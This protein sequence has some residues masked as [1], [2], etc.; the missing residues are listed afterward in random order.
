MIGGT[1]EVDQSSGDFTFTFTGNVPSDNPLA[2]A[3]SLGADTK[4]VPKAKAAPAKL[5]GVFGNLAKRAMNLFLEQKRAGRT[6]VCKTLAATGATVKWTG[7]GYIFSFVGS[8]LLG[9]MCQSFENTSRVMTFFLKRAGVPKEE[10]NKQVKDMQER[11]LDKKLNDPDC[12]LKERAKFKQIGLFQIHGKDSRSSKYIWT[13]LEGFAYGGNSNFT[14][15]EVIMYFKSALEGQGLQFKDGVSFDDIKNAKTGAEMNK[16][17]TNIKSPELNKPD[18][19]GVFHNPLTNDLKIEGSK[20]NYL[21]KGAEACS[22]DLGSSLPEGT[23]PSEL[24]RMEVQK[25]LDSGVKVT[26]F[27]VA[28]DYKGEP[29]YINKAKADK[30]KMDGKRLDGPFTLTLNETDLWKEKSDQLGLNIDDPRNLNVRAIDMLGKA[31]A[32][33]Y[34]AKK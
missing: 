1:G 4:G 9:K 3:K 11:C 6:P 15:T 28:V 33:R 22:R 10:L 20:F 16:L 2:L 23:T 21:Q 18:K 34:N 25:L 32:A 5:D 8:Y 17:V 26:E 24:F 30:L 13:P 31:A 19:Y 29:K 27:Y 14:D 7:A 12:S